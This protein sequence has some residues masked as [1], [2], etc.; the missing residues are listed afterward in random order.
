MA[1][2]HSKAI[3]IRHA[4]SADADAI[5]RLSG[6]LGYPS[7]EAAVRERLAH[8]LAA[9]GPHAVMVS[10]DGRGAVTGW[11]H[12]SLERTVESDPYVEI[13]GLVVEEAHRGK[14]IGEALVRAA[15]AWARGRGVGKVRVRSN[16]VRERTRAF[17]LRLGFAVRK[18]QAVFD[19]DLE[20]AGGAMMNDGADRRR[21][22]HG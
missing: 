15:V 4:I 3:H 16:V 8:L 6:E 10:V 1:D 17:Y 20:G 19:F 13:R 2:E 5:A 7:T 11:V 12:A 18:T 9:P 14:G 22:H 21:G